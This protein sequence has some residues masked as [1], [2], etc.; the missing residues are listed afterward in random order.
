MLYI[1]S[2]F[3]SQPAYL[4]PGS[5][6]ILIQL[7]LAMLVGIGVALHASWGKIKSLFGAKDTTQDDDNND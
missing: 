6:S 7:L 2:I 4:D 3:T 5:G 1:F